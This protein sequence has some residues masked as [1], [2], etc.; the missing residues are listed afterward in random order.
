[1]SNECVIPL[2]HAKIAGPIVSIYF[3]LGCWAC[4]SP[5][6]Q[7]GSQP[8][9]EDA[10]GV[11]KPAGIDLHKSRTGNCDF[12]EYHPLRVAD[13]LS[14]GG[15]SKRVE[16]VYPPEAKRRHLRGKVSVRVLINR[17]GEVEQA[18][19]MGNPL[20]RGAAEEAALQWLFRTPEL[21]GVRIPYIE[22]TLI[23]DFVLD[24][25]ENRATDITRKAP[26]RF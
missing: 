19:G 9:V 7:G 2:C 18:C 21:N 6:R 24:G 17:N 13:W 1:V 22:Q 5:Q 25:K 10:T 8:A 12:S 23:F 3:A 14:H 11:A 20:L 4:A 16:S 26:K 15:I